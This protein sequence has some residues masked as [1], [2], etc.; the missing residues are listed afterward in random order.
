MREDGELS[1]RKDSSPLHRLVDR[2][3][4]QLKNPLQAIVVNAEVVRLRAGREAPDLWAGLERHAAAIDDNVRLLNRRIQLMVLLARAADEKPVAVDPAA[5]ILDLVGAA[6]LDADPVPV[7]VENADVGPPAIA[8]PG[9]LVEL[10][11]TI[12]E[13]LGSEEGE[14]E[15][16]EVCVTVGSAEDGIRVELVRTPPLAEPPFSGD[17]WGELAALALRAGGEARRA[18]GGAGLHLLFPVK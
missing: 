13:E 4:H 2:M 5:L 8:R 9:C 16:G 11:F 14:E 18:A 1:E 17:E 3:S 12:L 15:S 10:L 7:R 6:H